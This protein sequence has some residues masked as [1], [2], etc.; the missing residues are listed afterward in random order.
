MVFKSLKLLVCALLILGISCNKLRQCRDPSVG[1]GR[2]LNEKKFVMI[3]GSGAGMGNF[4]VFFPSAYYFA[5]LTG[6]VSN[7]DVIVLRVNAANS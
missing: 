4:L 3:T 5:V 2:K 6:R 1:K 7:V